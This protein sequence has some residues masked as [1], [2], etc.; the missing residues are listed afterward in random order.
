MLNGFYALYFTGTVANGFAV[1]VLKDGVVAGADVAGGIFDGEYT[2]NQKKG[3]FEGTIRMTVPPG[4][5]LVTGAPPSQVTYTQEITLS[6]PLDL[7]QGQPMQIQTSTG[8][9]NLNMKKLRDL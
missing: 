1:V 6:L 4:I 7:N 8:P 2:V 5:S 3:V 9:V